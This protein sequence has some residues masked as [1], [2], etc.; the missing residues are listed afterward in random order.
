MTVTA[1]G[2]NGFTVTLVFE[3]TDLRS[4]MRGWRIATLVA[5][6]QPEEA[7]D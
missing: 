3:V 1:T 6:E 5:G 2:T 4:D 7:T